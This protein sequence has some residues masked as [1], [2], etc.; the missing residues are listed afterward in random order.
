MDVT[1]T[2]AEPVALARYL[3]FEPDGAM[4]TANRETSI[5]YQFTVQGPMADIFAR[6]P[7]VLVRAC[8]CAVAAPNGPP[9]G[10]TERTFF[11]SSV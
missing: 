6:S 9:L 2:S 3:F 4:G 1:V 7:S 11:S 8:A 5:G 10:C